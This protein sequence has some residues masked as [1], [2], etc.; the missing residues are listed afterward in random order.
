MEEREYFMR[1][2]TRYN[3]RDFEDFALN[4]VA[5]LTVISIFWWVIDFFSLVRVIVYILSLYSAI[6]VY[7]VVE[8]LPT[9][10]EFHFNLS[11]KHLMKGFKLFRGLIQ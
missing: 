9:L 11:W 6:I 8:A 3:Q 10:V 1:L 4:V 7:R 5:T 2:K